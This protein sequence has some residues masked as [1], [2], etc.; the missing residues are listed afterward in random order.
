SSVC[1][2]Q[3]QARALSCDDPQGCRSLWHIIWSCAV[4]LF[5]CTWVSVHPN[6]PSPDET[7]LQV[8]MRRLGLMLAALLIPEA[9]IALALRQRLAADELAEKYK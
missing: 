2:D 9:M 7:W 1:L 3:F 6:I 4:T 8:T 5:L